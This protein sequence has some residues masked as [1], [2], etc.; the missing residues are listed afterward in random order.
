MS[1]KVSGP[2]VHSLSPIYPDFS[3]FSL[4]TPVPGMR[5][6]SHRYTPKVAPIWPNLN[7]W[8]VIEVF[9]SKIRRC[10]IHTNIGGSA[11]SQTCS[12]HGIMQI[13]RGGE[14]NLDRI[15][16][17]FE[18]SQ[19]SVS[20]RDSRQDLQ[21]ATGGGSP[22]QISAATFRCRSPIYKVTVQLKM[23]ITSPI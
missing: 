3:L 2:Y 18:F 14:L 4:H 7:R 10:S 6:P 16:S 15:C 1:I 9:Y 17:G 13:F 8:I 5:I 12:N 19:Y 21:G 22:P 23:P 20:N 11:G